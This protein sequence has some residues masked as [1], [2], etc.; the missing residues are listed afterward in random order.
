[1]WW[2]RSLQQRQV[3]ICSFSDNKRPLCA[4]CRQRA[5]FYSGGQESRVPSPDSNLLIIQRSMDEIAN[6][7]HE[8]I[9]KINIDQV[10]KVS[11]RNMPLLDE[12]LDALS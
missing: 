4:L 6:I 2:R 10:G 1:R 5:F 12:R 8:I 11:T 9:A 7:R 3:L